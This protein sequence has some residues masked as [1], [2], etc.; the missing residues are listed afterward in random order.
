[1][2]QYAEI[3]GTKI[4]HSNGQT[5]TAT[6]TVLITLVFEYIS[7]KLRYNFSYSYYSVF[8]TDFPI[9]SSWRV[10]HI[11]Q[12]PS[13]NLNPPFVDRPGHYLSVCLIRHILKPLVSCNGQGS[14]VQESFPHK[15]SQKVWW[16][17]LNVVA[18]T[19]PSIILGLT[20]FFETL[21]L[22]YDLLW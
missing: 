7:F 16:D 17:A 10:S 4:F 6:E 13:N 19:I 21:S 18:V 9:S 1:M 15:C 11:L 8:S 3:D 2:K 20:P 12:L 14:T 22:H 5:E